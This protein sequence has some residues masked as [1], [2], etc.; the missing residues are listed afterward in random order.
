M[1]FIQYHNK[2]SLWLY[3]PHRVHFAFNKLPSTTVL[4][5]RYTPPT[6]KCHYKKYFY[7]PKYICT[8][9]HTEGKYGKK[10]QQ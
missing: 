1:D 3:I 4:L 9:T 5:H 7:M 8:H 2:A 6:G 10:M